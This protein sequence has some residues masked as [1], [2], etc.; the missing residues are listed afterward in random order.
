MFN[1]IQRLIMAF[2]G[3]FYDWDNEGT[4]KAVQFM[5]DQINTYGFTPKSVISED[6]S[7]RT[8]NSRMANMA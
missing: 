2:D 4:R 7:L 5:Y 3:D 6:Y 8:R 1:D